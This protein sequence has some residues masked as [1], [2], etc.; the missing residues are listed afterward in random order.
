M[1]SLLEEPP[2]EASREV[3]PLERRRVEAVSSREAFGCH[4]WFMGAMLCTM[5]GAMWGTFIGC[6][7]G[8]ATGTRTIFVSR[9]VDWP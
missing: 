5:W 1:S 4:T 9:G 2:V 8:A 6:W 7:N 3:L